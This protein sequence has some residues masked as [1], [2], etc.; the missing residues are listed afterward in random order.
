MKHANNGRNDSSIRLLRLGVALVAPLLLLAQEDG[1]TPT[2]SGLPSGSSVALGLEYVKSFPEDGPVRLRT[3]V[4]GSIR[5]YE[6]F[7]AQLLFPRLLR[8][9]AFLEL[10]ARYRNFPQED[11]WGLGPDSPKQH[12]S[13]FRVEDVNYF[14][15]VGLRPHPF[16]CLGL[17]G[18][19]LEVNTGPGKDRRWPS[20]EQ[21]FTEAQAPAL[22]R[23]PDYYHFGTFA[24]FDYRDNPDDPHYGGNYLFQWTR[25]QDRDFGRFSFRRFDVE[26]QQFFGLAQERATLALRALA[27]FTARG[28][29]QEVPFFM[30]P[31]V[32]GSGGLRGFHQYRFR[33]RNA[34][35]L[36]AEARVPLNGFLD[37]VAFADV[38][39][40]FRQPGALGLRGMAPSAGLGARLKLGTRVFVGLDAGFSREG[41]RV[42]VRGSHTF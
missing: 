28:Q 21:L 27:T 40:V 22:G 30:Q 24:Q 36:N 6:R 34:L 25:Y 42:W 31:T 4:I 8:E 10:T 19:L 35:V 17:T 16:L 12:R 9:K 1:L 7:E 41:A 13:N 15:T 29:G 3:L 5:K 2:L 18:G 11:F 23:Q 33:D 14:G 39:K 20:T 32:G 37:G 38:G 26:L